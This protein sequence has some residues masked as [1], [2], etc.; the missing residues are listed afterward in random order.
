[1]ALSGDGVAFTTSGAFNHLVRGVGISY[2]ERFTII[3]EES[4]SIAVTNGDFANAVGKT[5]GGTLGIIPIDV[6][7]SLGTVVLGQRIATSG[8]QVLS[9]FAFGLEEVI[10]L[11]S[12]REGTADVVG[13]RGIQGHNLYNERL[14]ATKSSECVIL[15]RRDKDYAELIVRLAS[16]RRRT[17][18]ENNGGDIGQRSADGVICATSGART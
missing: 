18:F 13:I 8:R 14:I 5:V 17:R 3:P 12:P 2:I 11:V 1:M 16:R 15:G 9:D 4:E 7:S 6:N 10:L